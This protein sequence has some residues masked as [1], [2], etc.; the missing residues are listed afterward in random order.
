MRDAVI[1]D[2]VRTPTGKGKPTGSLA[3]VRARAAGLVLQTRCEAGGLAN[4]TI[5]ECL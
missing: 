2:A 4:A 1:V 5:L 3:P